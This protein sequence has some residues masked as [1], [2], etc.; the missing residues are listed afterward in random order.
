[1]PS[2]EYTEN[3]VCPQCGHEEKDFQYEGG[4]DISMWCDECDAQ[5]EVT[6]WIDIRYKSF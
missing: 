3:P 1:M 5:Y 2:T 6:V 4:E